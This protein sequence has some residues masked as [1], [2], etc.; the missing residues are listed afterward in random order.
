M[1]SWVISVCII[2]GR[3][4][5]CA[6]IIISHAPFIHT[7][8]TGVVVHTSTRPFTSSYH[9]LAFALSTAK[10]FVVFQIQSKISLPN[11]TFS[12]YSLTSPFLLSLPG[13]KGGL[14]SLE[15]RLWSGTL[16]GSPFLH[17]ILGSLID[18]VSN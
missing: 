13:A 5:L 18:M 11:F 10:S 16:S 12:D 6:T 3:G 8:L 17:R 15:V 2:H 4:Q 14:T 1:I 7:V 9:Y